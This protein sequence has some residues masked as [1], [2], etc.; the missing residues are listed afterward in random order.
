MT[1]TYDRT[2]TRNQKLPNRLCDRCQMPIRNERKNKSGL[3]FCT[4]CRPYRKEYMANPRN[5]RRTRIET[6]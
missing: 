5:W 1:L 3:Y 2:D 4:D 6:S